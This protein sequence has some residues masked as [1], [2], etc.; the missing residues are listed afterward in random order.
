M[1]N[2]TVR[3]FQIV[4]N[5]KN[6]SLL[7]NRNIKIVG[8]R[9][10]GPCMED[11]KIV[12]T[13][14]S[15]RYWSNPADW[16]SKAVPKEG[17]DIH[18]EPGWDMIYDLTDSPVYRLI[19]VNGILT[20]SNATN[21]H[22]RC[23]HLFVRA[24]ELHI[25]SKDLPYPKQARITLYGAKEEDAIVYDNAIEGG[26]KLIANVNKIS[27]WGQARKQTVTRLTAEALFGA[28]SFK[29]EPGLDLVAGDR[30]GLAPTSFEL[31]AADY[32]HVTSYDNVTGLV[33]INTT[34]EHYHWGA[35]ASTASKYNGVD[36]RGEVMILSRNIIISGENIE[37]WGGQIVTSDTIE[38]DLTVRYG[39]TIMHNV[40]VYNCS[41]VNTM[42][43]AIRFEGASG[44]YSHVSN[45][46]FHNGLGW[47]VNIIS[48]ANVRFESNIVFSF[49][50]IGLSILTARNITIHNN[51]VSY[52]YERDLGKLEMFVDRRAG[53]T[54]CGLLFEFGD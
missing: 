43:A 36:I 46:S 29:V 47:G 15:K 50:P 2:E 41:Q 4:I 23:K 25:G 13:E 24:G 30:L 10:V 19:R 20:F 6:N 37:G 8:S 31:L 26:N 38:G 48:S 51:I 18:I 54:I 44:A 7:E 1:H 33:N 45:C 42:K 9:C 5:G 35:A 21:T 12:A 14:G 22:L 53:M 3:R 49:K 17:E 34:L 52:I 40:E 11:I 32:V 27:I 28:N 16:P 39:S